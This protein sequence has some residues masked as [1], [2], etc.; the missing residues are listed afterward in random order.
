LKINEALHKLIEEDV[1][2]GFALPLPISV[3]RKIP[4]ASLAPLGCIEQ[5]SIDS[6]GNK[7]KKFRMTHDQSFPGPS[8]LSVN[9]RVLKEQL[10]P[11]I[12]SYVLSR[13]IHYIVNLCRQHPKT[14][15]FICKVNLDSAYRRCHLSVSTAQESITSFKDL[16]FIALRMTFG[17]A[18][19]PSMWGYI[20]DTLADISNSL[21]GNLYWDHGKLFDLLSNTIEDPLS[22]PASIPF[23]LAK[24]L[25]INIPVNNLAKVDIYIDD[26]IGV[27]PDIGDSVIRVS[28]SIPLAIHSIARP[29]NPADS[30][31]RKDIISLKKFSAEGRMEETKI[32]LGWLV[33]TRT[34]TISLPEGKHSRWSTDIEKLL[35]A[36]K[37][38]FK[39][40]ESLTGHLNHVASIYSI[41]HHFMGRLYQAQFRS[42]KS[43]WTS[44][45]YNEKADLH[46]L[47][48][49]I[50]TAS[51]GI[52]VNL[53]VF[54]KP[55]LLYRS[56]ASEFGIGGYNL[57]SGQAWRFELPV[58][59]RLWTSLNSL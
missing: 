48:L 6:Q 34:L 3:I 10:P 27:A 8:G 11:I 19:C 51:K 50:Q 13:T 29:L 31:P 39:D 41:M 56:D 24:E 7:I 33:N 45:T 58:A 35:A 32:L 54:R 26:S 5:E 9:T 30:L 18:P 22:L 46:L 36:P 15:I 17:G 57:T 55:S 47:R 16:I 43:G 37:A 42:S 4:N 12:C 28:K 14:K 23:H 49:F 53:L 25:S 40:I 2:R 1:I 59:C 38:H 21:I 20:S 44:L 52:S